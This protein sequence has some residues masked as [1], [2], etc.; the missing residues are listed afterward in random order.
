MSKLTTLLGYAR[1]AGSLGVDWR[2]RWILATL[3]P[4]AKI[5]ASL[6]L[7]DDRVWQ[8]S[9][10]L[11]NRPVP[12]RLRTQDIFILNEIAVGAPYC[13]NWPDLEPPKVIIDLGAHIGLAT[14]QFKA[15]FP[16]ASVHCYEPD[17]DNFQL[18][19]ANTNHLD[20]VVVHQEAV[21][22]R[23]GEEMFY[24]RPLRRSGSSLIPSQETENAYGVRA[25]VRSLD[26]ILGDIGGADLIKFDIEGSEYDVF[27]AAQYVRHVR[28]VVG[29]IKGQ[30]AD[31]SRFCALF[32]EHQALVLSL[33][34]KL[35][36]VY[37]RTH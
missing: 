18:L 34:S 16:N 24:M 29:E 4:R 21:G 28:V 12:L 33:T 9:L 36:Y 17:R 37:L 30:K 23:S 2:S 26:D 19:M 1:M 10:Q 32:P 5:T 22:A 31:L 8:V 7:R 3:L 14:L 27:S 15:Y 20:R 25:C 6:G 13:P 35:H 11:A